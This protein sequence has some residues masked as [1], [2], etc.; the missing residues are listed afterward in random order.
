MT[1]YSWLHSFTL[2]YLV[3]SVATFAGC[4][5]QHMTILTLL[6]T[7]GLFHKASHCTRS[8]HTTFRK[9][10]P[11]HNLVRLRPPSKAALKA[12][13]DLILKTDG[14]E[15]PLQTYSAGSSQSS[16]SYLQFSSIEESLRFV[17]HVKAGSLDIEEGSVDADTV[18][19]KQTATSPAKVIYVKELP[20]E[21]DWDESSLQAFFSR[22]F[23]PVTRVVISRHGTPIILRAP[24]SYMT[25]PLSQGIKWSDLP[26]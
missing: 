2:C 21:G 23:G 6:S 7:S 22:K 4:T 9:S 11:Y 3:I 20:D 15:K 16:T 12:V 25:E 1:Q 18:S 24:R 14:I 8:F 10:V 19:A 5:Q 26:T 17:G 13:T